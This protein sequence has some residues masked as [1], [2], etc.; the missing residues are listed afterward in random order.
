[1]SDKINKTITPYRLD[2]KSADSDLLEMEDSGGDLMHLANRYYRWHKEQA[3]DFFQRSAK[4]NESVDVEQSQLDQD[5]NTLRKGTV[6]FFLHPFF[7]KYTDP[8]YIYDDRDNRMEKKRTPKSLNDYRISGKVITGPESSNSDYWSAIKTYDIVYKVNT[9]KQEIVYQYYDYKK[10]QIVPNTS[11]VVREKSFLGEVAYNKLKTIAPNTSSIEAYYHTKQV[12]YPKV[13]ESIS[14]QKTG[15]YT[16]DFSEILFQFTDNIAT[17]TPS[18]LLILMLRGSLRT[19]TKIS[20]KTGEVTFNDKNEALA[21]L[22]Q[23]VGAQGTI[24]GYKDPLG[25]SYAVYMYKNL[26][27]TPSW[28]YSTLASLN[29]DSSI[30]YSN[31]YKD[32]TGTK[33]NDAERI[34][35][36]LWIPLL[37]KDGVIKPY[38]T[39]DLYNDGANVNTAN[40]FILPDGYSLPTRLELEEF[41]IKNNGTSVNIPDKENGMPA[42][43]SFILSKDPLTG[44]LTYGFK[45]YNTPDMVRSVRGTDGNWYPMLSVESFFQPAIPNIHHS[46]NN[47]ES[48]DETI[49]LTYEE[50]RKVSDMLPIKVQNTFNVKMKRLPNEKQ[51]NQSKNAYEYAFS[52]AYNEVDYNSEIKQLKKLISSFEESHDTS[53]TGN[54]TET[55]TYKGYELGLDEAKEMITILESAERGNFEA[56][57]KWCEAND[58]TIWIT[59]VG[60][61]VGTVAFIPVVLLPNLSMRSAR[62]SLVE[63]GVSEE[64]A[65]HYAESLTHSK[66][67]PDFVKQMWSSDQSKPLYY[68]T[69]DLK[70]K[71]NRSLKLWKGNE[72]LFITGPTGVGKTQMLTYIAWALQNAEQAALEGIEVPKDLE[73]KL[74][75][76][77]DRIG[78]YSGTKYIG[79]SEERIKILRQWATKYG[80]SLFFDEARFLIGGGVAKGGDGPSSNDD[81]LNK[82]LVD[83]RNK[84]FRAAFATTNYEYEKYFRSDSEYAPFLRR[85]TQVE[86]EPYTKQ[87]VKRMLSDFIVPLLCKDKGYITITE[88][89]ISQIVDTVHEELPDDQKSALF[90][91]SKKK[92]ESLIQTAESDFHDD[93]KKNPDNKPT[94]FK[95]NSEFKNAIVKVE[96]LTNEIK[97]LKL[98]LDVITPKKVT[99]SFKLEDSKKIYSSIYRKSKGMAL[100]LTRYR[101]IKS[102]KEQITA[103]EK[104]LQLTQDKI[105]QKF[106][107]PNLLKLQ[108]QQLVDA[109]IRLEASSERIGLYKKYLQ[110]TKKAELDYTIKAGQFN[111]EGELIRKGETHKI[112]YE[113]YELDQRY[114]DAYRSFLSPEDKRLFNEIERQL[115]QLY[116]QQEQI[117]DEYND[118]RERHK[119]NFSDPR[120]KSQ[121]D[122]IIYRDT[123]ITQ[124]IS[125][126][127]QQ[128]AE[129]FL[130][131]MQYFDDSQKQQLADIKST[132]QTQNKK[133]EQVINDIYDLNKIRKMSSKDLQKEI[134]RLEKDHQKIQD[135]VSKLQESTSIMEEKVRNASSNPHN[136]STKLYGAVINSSNINSMLSKSQKSTTSAYK[137]SSEAQ[138]LKAE[139]KRLYGDKS[140]PFSQIDPVQISEGFNTYQDRH[141]IEAEKLFKHLKAAST[142]FE[143]RT[144]IT[145]ISQRIQALQEELVKS[146]TD[147][148]SQPAEGQPDTTI[149]KKDSPGRS[150]DI[151]TNPTEPQSP[152]SDTATHPLNQK[153]IHM[154]SAI[155]DTIPNLPSAADIDEYLTDF[156]KIDS[157]MTDSDLIQAMSTDD[158]FTKEQQDALSE[159]L[160]RT[161][162]I[163]SIPGD[164]D[165]ATAHEIKLIKAKDKVQQLKYLTVLESEEVN[166]L[167]NWAAHQSEAH[168]DLIIQYANLDIDGFQ[169]KVLPK[170]KGNSKL[171]DTAVKALQAEIKKLNSGSAGFMGAQAFGEGLMSTLLQGTTPNEAAIK[172]II[173]DIEP[174]T[175]KDSDEVTLYMRPQEPS[176]W[177]A[178]DSLS[179]LKTTGISLGA[180]IAGGMTAAVAS[181]LTLRSAA[182]AAD[183]EISELEYG[184]S[185]LI[186][187]NEAGFQ[188]NRLLQSAGIVAGETLD[189]IDST[190]DNVLAM[191]VSLATEQATSYAMTRIG[192][193]QGTWQN[194]VARFG[195]GIGAEIAFDQTVLNRPAV[196]AFAEKL[197]PPRYVAATGP[198]VEMYYLT[199]GVRL[200]SSAKETQMQKLRKAEQAQ[201]VDSWLST[202]INKHLKDNVSGAITWNYHDLASE[203]VNLGVDEFDTWVNADGKTIKRD[204][205]KS[206]SHMILTEVAKINKAIS[207]AHKKQRTGQINQQEFETRLAQATGTLWNLIEQHK[208]NPKAQ[209]ALLALTAATW[210][211]DI[212]PYRY[213]GALSK[214]N[215]NSAAEI[216]IASQLLGILTASTPLGKEV[217][218]AKQQVAKGLKQKQWYDS[219]YKD[220]PTSADW[221]ARIDAQMPKY[222]NATNSVVIQSFVKKQIEVILKTEAEV[223]A[224]RSYADFNAYADVGTANTTP[225][226]PHKEQRLSLLK[227][228]RDE[229]A[230]LVASLSKSLTDDNL[231]ALQPQIVADMKALQ[232]LTAEI[233]KIPSM[234]KSQ[235]ESQNLITKR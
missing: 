27:T 170:L 38:N 187:G 214:V 105:N 110:D 186:V 144:V 40:N 69:K 198:L 77:V 167:I 25:E 14:N 43:K 79:E 112:S 1:M 134:E 228:K 31:P 234:S 58:E 48:I 222:S 235:M 190:R 168:V 102:L 232:R 145:L 80:H 147:D 88:N 158:F 26:K 201:Y 72:P 47:L 160:P 30:D 89:A 188:T 44:E 193:E 98:Q 66:A 93:Y 219:Q 127:S 204:L 37:K 178:A 128:K 189:R 101:K 220:N 151:I 137:L 81:T 149:E 70:D 106:F 86:L 12:N 61:V 51:Y 194:T 171:K 10:R 39:I 139:V 191:P 75:F 7:K 97:L 91:R 62:K 207:S 84:S 138:Q 202:G 45:I 109:E 183:L 124:S 15:P 113:I 142:D 96:M 54:P 18:T 108:R 159:L 154:L 184:V 57:Y 164:S 41:L 11:S 223:K 150:S 71:I 180:N 233:S 231:K 226:D 172:A 33:F 5:I 132:I 74:L 119:G 63:S 13:Y 17:Y 129:L 176:Q 162:A 78:L 152:I 56:F 19:A 213:K 117:N 199:L 125:E 131:G 166:Q 90:D 140:S 53:D 165:R 20:L 114:K 123:E 126:L 224:K 59:V 107:D 64:T 120:L 67:K 143:K 230:A 34:S 60:A 153:W 203:L 133:Y 68:L 6:S 100:S 122:Q 192:Y 181:D 156:A 16:I 52:V 209:G 35:E 99:V 103:K 76:E 83:L 210:G 216:Q 196:K 197:I 174:S 22:N 169:N 32:I 24:Q 217:Q 218:Q 8:S 175:L 87:E 92:V 95:L 206:T 195:A 200:M 163:E 23:A 9:D 221:V 146:L 205:D 157:G 177:N 185:G 130:K 55:I 29:P 229:A 173:D 155:G 118:F 94:N 136:P 148:I 135:N 227:E 73:G 121:L 141:P 212:L 115:K 208:G 211:E 21:A 182:N 50:A 36:T 179:N 111:S 49:Y 104:E 161:Q 116:I 215:Q 42:T 46:Y 85:T 28:Y 4:T 3:G 65:K 82:L 225:I 2:P